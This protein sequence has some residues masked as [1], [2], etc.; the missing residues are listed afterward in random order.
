MRIER[1]SMGEMPVPDEVLY[2]AS[3]Q[4]AVLNFPVSGLRMPDRFIRAL[5]LVK[6]ASARVNEEL[7]KLSPEKSRMI[8]AAA[9]EIADGSLMSHFPIDVFQTGS[10]TSTNT[11]ANEV[12]ANRAAQ[13]AGHPIGSKQLLHPNDDVNLEQSSN[14]VIP[15]VLHVSVSLALRDDLTPA[16]ITM[17]ESL[18]SRVA[19]WIEVLK[20]G[21]THLMDATPL[22]L[23][24]E[25]S[26]YATQVRKGVE[27]ANRAIAA[28]GELAIGGTA[29]GTG[30][31]T[32][33]EFG[34]R[35]ATL[36]STQT[37]L[38]FREA[39]NH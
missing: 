15:T 24:Q 25:F 12:I 26:G 36:L 35:V 19:L 14:D 3:T 20:I 13:A 39:R 17:A 22:S 33:P 7:G 5:G 31:N 23:G 32:H 9:L 10:A 27:R 28:L 8:Q 11:N 21:R 37:G 4:R 29:V 30:I 34:T 18:E 2:G 38:P 6:W 1:D 16:L